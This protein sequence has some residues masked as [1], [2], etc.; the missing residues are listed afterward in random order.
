MEERLLASSSSCTLPRIPPIYRTVMWGKVIVG[1]PVIPFHMHPLST[2]FLFISFYMFH[3]I[4]SLWKLVTPYGGHRP[5]LNRILSMVPVSPVLISEIRF[6]MNGL[7]VDHF[8]IARHIHIC[9]IYNFRHISPPDF[10]SLLQQASP[11]S[12][13]SFP[14]H[15]HLSV[16]PF[17]VLVQNILKFL[18]TF[19]F[20]E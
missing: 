20:E 14:D 10:K 18:S 4:T 7:A 9:S 17:P 1:L 12:L 5:F 2:H 19:S 11:I 13:I 15:L 6:N 3:L 8:F 16:F